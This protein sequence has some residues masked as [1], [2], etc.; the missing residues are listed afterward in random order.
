MSLGHYLLISMFLILGGTTSI[1]LAK[2]RILHILG[3]FFIGGLGAV[4][5]ITSF[6][7]FRQTINGFIISLFLFFGICAF[8]LV[9]MAFF[10]RQASVK[11]NDG[12][13]GKP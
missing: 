2:S 4:L 8:V 5:S 7:Y 10:I 13:K 1:L 3:G 6:S 12:K 11:Q 9:C